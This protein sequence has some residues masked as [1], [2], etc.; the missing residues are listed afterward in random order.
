MIGFCPVCKTNGIDETE[1]EWYSKCFA[2]HSD[3]VANDYCDCPVHRNEEDP[4]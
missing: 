1:W 2:C 4:A 3:E